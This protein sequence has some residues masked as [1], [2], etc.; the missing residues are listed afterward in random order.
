MYVTF[1]IIQFFILKDAITCIRLPGDFSGITISKMGLGQY[2]VYTGDPFQDLVSHLFFLIISPAPSSFQDPKETKI[3]K[4]WKGVDTKLSQRSINHKLFMLLLRY[5]CYSNPF[6]QYYTYDHLPS[7]L[8][9]QSVKTFFRNS[10]VNIF[11][12]F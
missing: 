1:K 8:C 6:Q 10:N 4:I 5:K 11:P 7:K 9:H 3:P 2:T 12:C